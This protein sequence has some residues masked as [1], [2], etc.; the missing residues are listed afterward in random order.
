MET[1]CAQF[2]QWPSCRRRA[3]SMYQLLESYRGAPCHH[4]WKNAIVSSYGAQAPLET[5]PQSF[6]KFICPPADSSSIRRVVSI[7]DTFAGYLDSN[8]SYHSYFTS[9]TSNGLY[10]A[11]FNY[12]STVCLRKICTPLDTGVALG[13]SINGFSLLHFL[14]G[15]LI[16]SRIPTAFT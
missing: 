6:S 10:G 5:D 8:R 16:F 1:A 9:S 13:I 4:T 14:R 2:V 7:L 11:Y 15:F 3:W 12:V